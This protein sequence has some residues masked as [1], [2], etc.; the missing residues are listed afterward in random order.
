MSQQRLLTWT[1]FCTWL[2][3][4][5]VVREISEGSHVHLTF[6]DGAV[7]T[8]SSDKTDATPD[9]SEITPGSDGHLLP[10]S[11]MVEESQ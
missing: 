4:R 1:Q 3:G 7:A 5:R 8:L 2:G 10:P 6:S 11:V 9:W